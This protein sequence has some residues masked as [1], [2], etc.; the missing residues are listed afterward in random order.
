MSALLVNLPNIILAI[1]SISNLTAAAGR[2]TEAVK[3]AIAEK[4]D[5]TEA[6]YADIKAANDAT[7]AA[8][9]AKI[10]ALP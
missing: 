6:E 7:M 9:Q 4:R 1:D 3:T 8:A 5:L 2:W 10:D